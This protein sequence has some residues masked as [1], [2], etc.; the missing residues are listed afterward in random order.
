MTSE[1]ISPPLAVF[2]TAASGLW[3]PFGAP[4]HH[5]SFS[6][7]CPKFSRAKELCF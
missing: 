6:R 2:P 5:P 4:A 3:A 1:E 7:F